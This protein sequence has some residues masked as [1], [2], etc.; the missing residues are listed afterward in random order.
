MAKRTKTDVIGCD[1]PSR[2]REIML[3]S[4]RSEEICMNLSWLREI[5]LSNLCSYDVIHLVLRVGWALYR[6]REET[7]G[8]S[9][10]LR[11][12]K[13][14]SKT[15]WSWTDLA[16]FRK[17]SCRNP[18]QFLHE[19]IRQDPVRLI[20]LKI[21][22]ISFVSFERQ[23]RLVNKINCLSAFTVPAMNRLFWL[24]TSVK[25]WRQN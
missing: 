16:A 10:T 11:K 20:W 15:V 9:G 1:L 24:S 23:A 7:S 4:E 17:S 13:C 14:G 21:L 8:R 6:W 3:G 2:W 22:S 5:S 18:T 12:T 25:P 19:T